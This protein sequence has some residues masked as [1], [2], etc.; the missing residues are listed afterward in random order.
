MRGLLKLF[1]DMNKKGVPIPLIRVNGKASFTATM[2]VIAFHTA[3]FGQIG[4]VTKIIGDVDLSA[5]T[6]LFGI[7][8]GAYLGRQIQG[9]KNGK[10]PSNRK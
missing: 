3:L 10:V 9:V 1:V 4:K 5:A 6:Y 2:T 8:L 7:C